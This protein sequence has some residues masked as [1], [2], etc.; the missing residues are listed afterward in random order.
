MWKVYQEEKP[1]LVLSRKLGERLIIGEAIVVTVTQIDRG[2]VRLG[3]EAPANVDVVRE[4]LQTRAL[5]AH[6][7]GEGA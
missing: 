3:I 1:M 5:S 7:A 4:E 2:R 6:S